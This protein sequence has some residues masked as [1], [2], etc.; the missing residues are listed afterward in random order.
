MENVESQLGIPDPKDMAKAVKEDEAQVNDSP[1]ADERKEDKGQT[2]A[3]AAG[4][5]L[6]YLFFSLIQIF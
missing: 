5:G 1:C 6:F 4:G 3:E 2:A